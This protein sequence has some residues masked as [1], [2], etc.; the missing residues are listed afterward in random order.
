MLKIVLDTNVIVS[1]TIMN[2]GPSFQLLKAW[3]EDHYIL[4]VSE[5]IL[6][7]INRVFHYRHIMQKRRL[8]E[9]DIATVVCR[10]REY[11]LMVTGM[12]EVEA[13]PT[14]LED[15]KFVTAAMEGEADYIISGDQHLR[16]LRHYEDIAI[17]SPAEGIQ[18]L[19][20]SVE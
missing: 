19:Q 15:N 12:P 5:P 20:K 6:D 1:G 3:E 18:I 10:L 14:D 17:V 4:I 11:G 13:V 2:H 7:E 8:T 9:E 16:K